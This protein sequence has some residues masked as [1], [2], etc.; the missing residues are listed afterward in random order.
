MNGHHLILGEIRDFLSGEIITDT[1]DERYRQ[2]IA[3]F[4]VD[5]LGYKREEIH[6]RVDLI[7]KV[8]KKAAKLKVDYTISLMGKSAMIIKYGPGS[9]VTRRR[10]ALAASRLLCSYQIPFVVVTNGEDAETLD[11][12]SGK[13]ISSDIESIPP[14]EDLLHF[15]PRLKLKPIKTRQVEME[16]RILYAFEVDDSCPCDDTICRL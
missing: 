7:I 4:L 6:S 5:S 2:K 9:L 11:G 14:R 10:P 3:R 12:F 16:S 13:I 8:D 1:H 15:L